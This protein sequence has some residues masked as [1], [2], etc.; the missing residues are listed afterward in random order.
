MRRAAVLLALILSAWLSQTSRALA[1][2]DVELKH[3]TDGTLVVVGSGWHHGQ[4][5]VIDVGR[6][7]F[8]VR[9]DASGDFE[10]ATGLAASG[11]ELSVRHPATT[12][13]LSVAAIESTVP[14][15]FAVLFAWSVAF[16]IA[17]LGATAGS[18]LLLTGV[19]RRMRPSRYPRE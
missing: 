10:L 18:V 9:A 15:P 3:A 11:G 7:K 8:N 4:L 14:N 17:L 2:S 6:Q 5:L 12:P 1:A 19:L 13:D 16:G